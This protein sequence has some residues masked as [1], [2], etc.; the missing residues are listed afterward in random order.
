MEHLMFTQQRLSSPKIWSVGGGAGCNLVHFQHFLALLIPV[1]KKKCLEPMGKNLPR[2]GIHGQDEFRKIVY[3]GF[4]WLLLI[5]TPSVTIYI[6]ERKRSDNIEFSSDLNW[7][8]NWENFQEK[9]IAFFLQN[10][11]SLIFD[12][13]M[14]MMMMMSCFCKRYSHLIL[15]ANPLI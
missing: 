7:T 5:S 2:R 9:E 4:P 1:R 15:R 11:V 8:I 3:D 10:D 13:A 6:P 14:V 12:A